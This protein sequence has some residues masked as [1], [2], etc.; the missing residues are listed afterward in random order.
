MGLITQRGFSGDCWEN[1]KHEKVCKS[2]NTCKF[3]V[4][5][6]GPKYIDGELINERRKNMYLL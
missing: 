6:V 1:S 5:F 3:D 2:D 4:I